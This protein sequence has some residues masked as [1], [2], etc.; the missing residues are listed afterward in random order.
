LLRYFP[1]Y[2]AFTDALK[3]QGLGT[4]F[5]GY[6]KYRETRYTNLSFFGRVNY[7]LQDK[8]YLSFNVRRD[9]AS[10]FSEDHRWGYFPAGS[11]AWRVKNEKFLRNSRLIND[12]KFRAGFGTVGNNRIDDYLFMTSYRND[13]TYYYGINGQT[14][15]GYY[16]A[17]L[18]NQNLKWES[19]VNKNLGADLSLFKNR[20][21]IT[22]DVYENTSKDLLLYVPIA[23]TYGYT[24]QY[25]NIGKT[26]NKGM[27]FQLSGVILRKPKGLNWNANFNIAFN[28]NNIDQLGVNQ[29]FFYPAASWG[30]SG[31]PTDYIIQVGQTV[32]AMYG[33]VTDGFYTLNDF[34]YNN[35]V[36]TLRNGVV[37]DASI[38]GVVQPGA[39][40]F[41]DLNGDGVIDLNNDRKIIGNPTPKFTGG[42]NQQF[43]YKAWDL[44]LFVNFSYGNDI[45]NANKIE[46]TNGY[47]NNSNMLKIMEN[48]WK[49][50]T[51]TGETA[52][53]VSGT[54]VYGISPDRLGAINAHASIW[55]PIKSSGAFYPHSWAVEDGS[56]L[57]FNNLTIGYTF[58]A[59]K[60]V[61]TG[62]TKL[63]FYA[64]ANNFAIITK[65]TG[66]DPEVSV[67]SNPLTPGLDYSAYPKSKSFLFGINA[68]F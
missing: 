48:R 3:N 18:M 13:G 43:S 10:K 14:V 50:V 23:S 51:P 52:Q 5:A 9:G 25:Q 1:T 42:L 62:I 44:S 67:R 8:Y 24:T 63:R 68:S 4:S 6:P 56:F 22:A 29:K 54:T 2:T 35:G 12:L 7:N 60:L 20:L 34:N 17:N 65:Y 45:Y 31:Q 57:R 26:T 49:V 16:P 30:V 37:S 36:Y 53:W 66:Y 19:T 61:G 27:E 47:S 55:Q 58:P 21:N 39:I 32:G 11:I 46:M 28:K 38:V 33:L 40:K 64:T 41:K 59:T 15:M